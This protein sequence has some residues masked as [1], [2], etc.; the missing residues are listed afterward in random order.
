MR[1]SIFRFAIC[2]IALAALGARSPSGAAPST[3]PVASASAPIQLVESVPVE[4]HLGNP[5]LPNAHD[6]WL[7][8]IRGAKRRLDLEQFYLSV[9]PG[10]LMDDVVGE[11]GMAAARG[12]RVRLILDKRMHETYPRTA[13]SLARL[14]GIA[15]RILDIAK[16]SGGG[17]QHSKYFLVDGEQTY[18]GSQ[19]FD[20]RSLKHIHELG[21]R[22]RDPRV[23]SEFQRVFDMDWNVST[24]ADSGVV[25]SLAAREAL[26]SN[27]LRPAITLPVRIVQAAGDTVD[28]WTGYT[29]HGFIPD[30]TRWDRDAI[31]RMLDAARHEIVAQTLT[32]SSAERNRSDDALDSALRRAARRGVRVRLMVSDW[33]AGRPA[34]R[35]LDSLAA[36]PNVEVRL[37]VVPEWS[38]SYIPFARVEHCKYATVDSAWTWVGTSNWEPGYFHGSRN[39]GVTM[40]NRRLA[41]Q[42]RKIFAASWAAPTAIPVHSG[43]TYAPRLHG[44]TPPPGRTAYGQ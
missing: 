13:D 5:E 32:Y 12:V 25:D 24:P 34:M 21:V 2:L 4:T 10:E 17:V 42:A 43:A 1:F 6:V 9:W 28:V 16:F 31:V 19:N 29:P 37:S 8:M 33:E 26:D 20:W 18:L 39:L 23:T 44:A 35:E 38:K 15:V 41:I 11:V 40:R 14:P 27:G 7:E 3:A 22:V 36:E 30:S